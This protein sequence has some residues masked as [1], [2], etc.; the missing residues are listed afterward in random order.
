M[1]D[2][3]FQ[4]DLQQRELDVVQR[5]I[6]VLLKEQTLDSHHQKTKKKKKSKTDKIGSPRNFEHFVAVRRGDGGLKVSSK[7]NSILPI[8]NRPFVNSDSEPDTVHSSN[9]GIFRRFRKAKVRLRK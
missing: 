3:Q 6:S 2:S 9:K 7:E 1:T 5:E 8:S 4:Q